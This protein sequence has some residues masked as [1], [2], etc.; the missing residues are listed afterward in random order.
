MMADSDGNVYDT[1]M[2]TFRSEPAKRIDRQANIYQL[3]V[4][5][6]GIFSALRE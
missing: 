2:I 5:V 4:D 1:G 3:E 6:T